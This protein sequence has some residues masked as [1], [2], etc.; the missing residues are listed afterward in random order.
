[1]GC[2]QSAAGANR[3]KST[4]LYYVSVNAPIDF[5]LLTPVADFQQSI[6]LSSS[7][8]TF[9]FGLIEGFEPKTCSVSVK[10]INK[11]NFS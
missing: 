8:S 11:K 7:P 3:A 1:M 6:D 5:S 2:L 10:E 4:L 9:Y